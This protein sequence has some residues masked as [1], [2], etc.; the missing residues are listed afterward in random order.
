M[1]RVRASRE[2]ARLCRESFLVGP[3]LRVIERYPI[4]IARSYRL[5]CLDRVL[6]E[7]SV[8]IL[9]LRMFLWFFYLL[10][11]EPSFLNGHPPQIRNLL[12]HRKILAR[13]I[14]REYLSKR[15]H[16]VAPRKNLFLIYVS[17]RHSYLHVYLLLLMFKWQFLTGLWG[18]TS[19]YCYPT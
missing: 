16:W 13:K 7:G 1:Y 14:H 5:A 2:G 19:V 3:W 8:L 12:P 4:H 11:V 9:I 18:R 17:P 15:Y 10:C 6:W